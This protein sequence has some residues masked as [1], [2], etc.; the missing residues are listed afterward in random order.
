[1]YRLL[2]NLGRA[3]RDPQ[4]HEHDW[5]E[6]GPREFLPKVVKSV[7]TARASRSTAA[8]HSRYQVLHACQE[9]CSA[10]VFLAALRAPSEYL[11]GHLKPDRWNVVGDLEV[12]NLH[13]A[14]LVAAAA[15]PAAEVPL[16]RPP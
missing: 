4:H 6:A 15:G 14:N 2:A 7:L 9:P 11:A 12:D 5:R 13:L 10:V 16:D 8:R 3:G 1:V